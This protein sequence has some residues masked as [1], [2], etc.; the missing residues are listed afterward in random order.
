MSKKQIALVIS[1]AVVVAGAAYLLLRSR[2]KK[3]IPKT[4]PVPVQVQESVE[5]LELK[6]AAGDNGAAC[7][8]AILL[9]QSG[10]SSNV[11]QDVAR[12]LQLLHDAAES[13]A[14]EAM[15]CAPPAV[16]IIGCWCPF[17]L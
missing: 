2:P 15:M 14:V 3:Q 17:L 11:P 8:L 1:G 10:A 5:E 16:L 12:A 4:L 9:L 13:G 6:V 7:R